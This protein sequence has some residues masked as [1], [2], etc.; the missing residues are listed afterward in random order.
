MPRALAETHAKQL[1]SKIVAID[2]LLCELELY[3]LKYSKFTEGLLRHTES[4]HHGRW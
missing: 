1:P 2:F 3:K 4:A